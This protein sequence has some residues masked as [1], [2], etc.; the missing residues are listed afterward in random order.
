[1]IWSWAQTEFLLSARTTIAR[2]PSH[3]L[4]L[5]AGKMGAFSGYIDDIGVDNIVG[6][7]HI[8]SH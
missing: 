6:T 2:V 8:S 7:N 4:M 5:R 3:Y 1:M